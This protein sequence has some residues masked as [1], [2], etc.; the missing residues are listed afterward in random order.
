MAEELL[1][2][3]DDTFEIWQLHAT[4]VTTMLRDKLKN[5]DENMKWVLN[6][7]KTL[8][9]NTP[10]LLRY[11]VVCEII[12]SMPDK[13]DGALDNQLVAGHLL[14]CNELQK[15]Q[16]IGNQFYDIY[17]S[18]NP[19]ETLTLKPMLNKLE[20]HLKTLLVKYPEEPLLLQVSFAFYNC[21]R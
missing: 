12:K 18:P 4:V 11:E 16:H 19:G 8:D 13:L 5:S 10:Y 17:H 20:N 7:S 6:K 15:I 1:L 9:F 21:K 2:T 14:M 3:P